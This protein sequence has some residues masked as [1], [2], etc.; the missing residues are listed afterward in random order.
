M[1]TCIAFLSLFTATVVSGCKEETIF[2]SGPSDHGSLVDPRIQPRVLSTYPPAN[3]TGPFR[4]YNP[5]DGKGEPHFVIVFNKLMDRDP[6]RSGGVKVS[7]FDRPVRVS[8]TLIGGGG[9]GDVFSFAVYDSGAGSTKLFFAIGRTYTV[10]L[11]TTLIDINGNRLGGNDRFSFVAEPG[12][13]ILSVQPPAN[14]SGVST[15]PAIAVLFN[16]PVDTSIIHSLSLIPAAGGYWEL[17]YNRYSVDYHLPSLLPVNTAYHI[18]VLQQASDTLGHQLTGPF[19]SSF[20]TAGFGVEST[21]P[22]NG[23]YVAPN[24]T[25]SVTFAA[26]VDPATV[27]P[28]FSIQPAVTG[29]FRFSPENRFTFEPTGGFAGGRSYV[30]TLS[31][32]I[33]SS[34]GDSLNSPYVF[35]FFVEPFGIWD[36]TP[37]S[38]ES[39]VSRSRTLSVLFNGVVDPTS[40]ASPIVAIPDIPGTIRWERSSFELIPGD[41]LFPNQEYLITVSRTIRSAAGDTLGGAYAYTFSTGPH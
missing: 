32:G 38:G 40:T 11:D 7:G 29:I 9:Y 3:G 30:V 31:T 13:R 35:S 20:V 24:S 36:V 5:G 25:A 15:N 8:G 21:S 14:A 12:F 6:L 41:S 28:G 22:R 34:T 1:K 26:A 16:G 19:S 10:T 33:Q 39:N 23:D 2:S 17:Q 37:G 18:A 27:P 4:I